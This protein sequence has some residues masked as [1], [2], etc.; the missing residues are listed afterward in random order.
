[1]TNEQIEKF[2]QPGYLDKSRV[3]I[4]FKTRPSIN[5]MFIQTSDYSSLKSKNLW[6][7]VSESK[8]EQYNTSKD[9]SLARIFNGVE[10]TRLSLAQQ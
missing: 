7:I 5:G 1:M 9:T 8:I 10:I 2:L 4:N 3:Q 6:R